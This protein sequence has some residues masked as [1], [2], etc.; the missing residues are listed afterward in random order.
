MSTNFCL[1]LLSFNKEQIIINL[2]N[3]SKK[4]EN[5]GF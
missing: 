3:E 5:T 4:A 2:Y 1:I